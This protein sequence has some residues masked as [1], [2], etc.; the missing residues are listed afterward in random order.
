MWLLATKPKN[1]ASRKFGMVPQW[2]SLRRAPPRQFPTGLALRFVWVLAT[3]GLPPR[4]PLD[5]L[6]V[7]PRCLP[8][9]RTQVGLLLSL[10]VSSMTFCPRVLRPGRVLL[11]ALRAFCLLSAAEPRLCVLY[12]R[13]SGLMSVLRRS[14]SWLGK[15]LLQLQAALK[16]RRPPN[17]LSG[18]LLGA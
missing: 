10:A 13:R 8:P 6:V 12:D 7:R 16:P 11:A 3:A 14:P 15:G 5:R 2:M 1:P 17:G 9:L 18:P 4:V